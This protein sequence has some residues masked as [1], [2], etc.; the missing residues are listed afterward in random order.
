LSPFNLNP[1]FL[2][3]AVANCQLLQTKGSSGSFKLPASSKKG[4]EKKKAA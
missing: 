1:S 4:G 3:N 2:K